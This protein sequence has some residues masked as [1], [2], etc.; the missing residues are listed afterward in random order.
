M[1]IIKLNVVRSHEHVIFTET[2][3]KIALSADNDK[4]MIGKDEI[5]SFSQGHY[6][7]KS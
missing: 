3:N 4:R 7:I 2:I 1:Q 5:S 6:P